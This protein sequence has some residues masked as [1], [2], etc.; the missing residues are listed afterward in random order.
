MP[1][2][3][4]RER[5]YTSQLRRQ[6]QSEKP[7]AVNRFSTRIFFVLQPSFSVTAPGAKKILE[8]L[9]IFDE[10]L[11]FRSG[12]L[13]TVTLSLVTLVRVAGL[14]RLVGIVKEK[15]LTAFFGHIRD[16]ADVFLI[17]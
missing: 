3:A 17:V 2:V 9:E 4:P 7:A 5:T 6:P 8:R 15:F 12:K 1:A 16:E 10:S 11:F 14:F 13:G